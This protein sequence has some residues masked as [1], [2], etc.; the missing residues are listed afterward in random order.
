MAELSDAERLGGAASLEAAV[1]I[2]LGAKHTTK[3]QLEHLVNQAISRYRNSWAF[4]MFCADVE[5]YCYTTKDFEPLHPL[6][7]NCMEAVPSCITTYVHEG[8]TA[9]QLDS[10]IEDIQ[11]ATCCCMLD[12]YH[13]RRPEVEKW[14]DEQ[15]E[16]IT[17]LFL[18]SN[19]LRL[20]DSDRIFKQILATS[21]AL[22]DLMAGLHDYC[23]MSDLPGREFSFVGH[24][25]HEIRRALEL[26]VLSKIFHEREEQLSQSTLDETS[27]ELNDRLDS[28]SER[29]LDLN[30]IPSR[31]D[32]KRTAEANLD[33]LKRF[34]EYLQSSQYELTEHVTTYLDYKELPDLASQ[35][36]TLIDDTDQHPSEDRI[37][38]WGQVTLV[39]QFGERLLYYTAD[40]VQNLTS[41]AL[42]DS[43]DEASSEEV[44]CPM[45]PQVD[46]YVS[47][48]SVMSCHLDSDRRV[49]LSGYDRFAP[50]PDT[51]EYREA[52]DTIGRI[53]AVLNQDLLEV[54]ENH[55]AVFGQVTNLG[56]SVFTQNP[57]GSMHLL[58][59]A[60][61][62]ND[63]ALLIGSEPHTEEQ[64][65]ELIDFA[66]LELGGDWSSFTLQEAK[67]VATTSVT[68]Q[69]SWK[70]RIR[71]LV[72]RR[73]LSLAWIEERLGHFCDVHIARRG[74][75]SSLIVT[76][77]KGSQGNR[78]WR[79]VSNTGPV[80]WNVLWDALAT[81]GIDHEEFY[82]SLPK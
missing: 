50:S 35:L 10:S 22:H 57:D 19:G 31:L 58:C 47:L 26:T 63:I 77:P 74:E 52:C 36:R 80:H 44:Y 37:L 16:K 34:L 66:R 4:S 53:D 11:L 49:Y 62:A 79:S 7:D 17:S 9:F 33:P 14:V 43:E 46:C 27:L 60:S 59:P 8:V 29:R 71:E 3:K 24:C 5:T 76:P 54:W 38:P 12:G 55:P 15:A 39:K 18:K 64:T 6:M 67:E 28:F 41:I 25:I 48:P 1:N 2:A 75:R 51:E 68:V 72:N 13:R 78:Y 40:G 42:S 20:D 81:I 82:K 32:P 61:F 30:R 69:T 56:P 21:A 23:S 73:V 65:T 45:T 70:K